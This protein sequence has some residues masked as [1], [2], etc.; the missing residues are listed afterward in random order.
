M[1]EIEL[2]YVVQDEANLRARLEQ[3][4]AAS[5]GAEEQ[6]ADTYYRHPCRDF[7]AT[8]EALRI[9]RVD[10]Q[11]HVTYKG[12]REHARGDGLKVRKELEWELAPGDAS[13]EKMAS[14]LTALGFAEVTTVRKRRSSFVLQQPRKVVITID[15]VEGLGVFAEVEILAA[16][17]ESIEAAAKC[18]REIAEQLGL[19]DVQASSYL[20][21]VLAQSAGA[22]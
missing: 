12:P 18:L 13:G 16:V 19:H 20:G 17:D 9:R 1:H 10:D 15:T 11:P 6:H 21:L 2:K 22:N 8:G 7:R 3:L 4:G 5:A 14:L